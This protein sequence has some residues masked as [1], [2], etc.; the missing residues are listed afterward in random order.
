MDGREL[1]I[2][3]VAHASTVDMAVGLLRAER[4]NSTIEDLYQIGNRVPYCSTAVLEREEGKRGW[5][6]NPF[7]MLPISYRNFSNVF[8]TSF[9]N[10]L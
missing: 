9:V 6:P 3:V 1:N 5:K 4:R 7:A 2:L 8:L 10:R